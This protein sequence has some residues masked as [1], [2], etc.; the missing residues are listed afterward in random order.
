MLYILQLLYIYI[1]TH[2]GRVT[3]L[4]FRSETEKLAVLSRRWKDKHLLRDI[5]DPMERMPL[6]CRGPCSCMVLNVVKFSGLFL[7]AK[8]CWRIGHALTLFP[9]STPE[10]WLLRVLAEVSAQEFRGAKGR[11]PEDHRVCRSR[12]W[13]GQ[14]FC[15]ISLRHLDWMVQ[16]WEGRVG[17]REISKKYGLLRVLLKFETNV[18]TWS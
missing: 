13:M 12:N 6:Q 2:I 14:R 17:I 7:S 1:R 5:I 15:H 18:G 11:R 8:F 16:G 3:P 9:E 10:G 4:Q